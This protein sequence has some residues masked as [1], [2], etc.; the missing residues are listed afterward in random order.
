MVKTNMHNAESHPTTVYE[1][2]NTIKHLL[3]SDSK[4]LHV[5]NKCHRQAFV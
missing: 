5:H 4:S 2:G 1:I 3:Q